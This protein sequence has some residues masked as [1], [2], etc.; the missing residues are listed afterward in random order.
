M[1][2]VRDSIRRE[3]HGVRCPCCGTILVTDTPKDTPLTL[4]PICPVCRLDL[5]ELH[6]RLFM[7]T[8]GTEVPLFI[9]TDDAWRLVL[10]SELAEPWHSVVACLCAV[11]TD[12]DERGVPR[13][14]RDGVPRK[15]R[16]R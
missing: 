3:Y 10:A 1:R 2:A 14:L 9:G 11:L 6:A 5:N 16:I 4:D 13:A 8:N 15:G 7:F 12:Q